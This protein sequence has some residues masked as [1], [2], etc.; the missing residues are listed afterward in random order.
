MRL[1]LDANGWDESLSNVRRFA[2]QVS[3][4]HAELMSLAQAQIPDGYPR[5]SMKEPG[6][7]T[8]ET[9]ESGEPVLPH[10]D[11]T[12]SAVEG[13]KRLK[14][15]EEYLALCSAAQKLRDAEKA[16]QAVVGI[17]DRAKRLNRPKVCE[18]SDVWCEHHLAFGLHESRGHRRKN[19]GTETVLCDWCETFLRTQGMRPPRMLLEDRA[20][21][22]RI[23]EQKIARAKAGAG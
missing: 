19:N 12:F 10:A 5:A 20:Q 7:P 9:D 16:M 6:S 15:T 2:G 23:T 1:I 4:A 17:I 11:P 13:R 22:K 14:T 18:D 8:N 3:H 21:G